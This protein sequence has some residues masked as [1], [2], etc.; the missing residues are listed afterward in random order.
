MIKYLQIKVLHLQHC[1]HTCYIQRQPPHLGCQATCSLATG[2]VWRSLVVLGGTTLNEHLEDR[3]I[4]SSTCTAGLA[5]GLVQNFNGTLSEE[6]V[7][8]HAAPLHYNS[9]SEL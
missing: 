5:D 9:Y 3:E 8:S 6:R 4:T 7:C 1:N 2:L